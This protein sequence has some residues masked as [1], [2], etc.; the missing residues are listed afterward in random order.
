[1]R[2]VPRRLARF[3]VVSQAEV[4]LIRLVA[5]MSQVQVQVQVPMLHI[6]ASPCARR[7]LQEDLIRVR[8]DMLHRPPVDVYDASEV[9]G[10]RV[11]G[12][13]CEGFGV[14]VFK[15]QDPWGPVDVCKSPRG[16]Q[17]A[18]RAVVGGVGGGPVQRNDARE[19]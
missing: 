12:A 11:A 17:V 14:E 8:T 6:Q 13:R 9:G 4:H 2:T 19:R 16:G 1:M 5:G 3:S 7:V 15:A 18:S 10:Y